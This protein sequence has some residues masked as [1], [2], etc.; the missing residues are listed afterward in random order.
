VANYRVSPNK[1]QQQWDKHKDK[2]KKLNQFRLFTFKRKFLKISVDLHTAL[3]AE[4]H[5]AEGQWLEGQLNVV[6]LRAI[7]QAVSGRPPTAATPVQAQIRTCGI[8]GEQ[9]GTGAGFI[10]VLRFPLPILIPLTAPHSPSSII[11]GWYNRPIS[12]RRTKRTQG[13]PTPRN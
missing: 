6:K 3:A 7:A 13:H 12:G 10:R 5:L 4:A 1:K 9:S 11:R 8:C 2:I